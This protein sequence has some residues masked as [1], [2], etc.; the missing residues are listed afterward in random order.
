MSLYYQHSKEYLP[1]FRSILDK[2]NH[3][4]NRLQIDKKVFIDVLGDF[5]YEHIDNFDYK[6]ICM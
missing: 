2:A 6:E 4:Q 1:L 5:I 3:I